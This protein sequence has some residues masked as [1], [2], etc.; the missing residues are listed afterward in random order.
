MKYLRKKGETVRLSYSFARC[1][2][3]QKHQPNS[4]EW[5][6]THNANYFDTRASESITVWTRH[7]DAQCVQYFF[8]GSDGGRRSR[9]NQLRT[10]ACLYCSFTILAW[11]EASACD[12]APRATSAERPGYKKQDQSI[13][14]RPR[15]HEITLTRKIKLKNNTSES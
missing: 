5:F 10:K 2:E 4:R 6:C 7:V 13:Q 1:V 11:E 12:L 9:W 3:G 14:L 15:L 8:R